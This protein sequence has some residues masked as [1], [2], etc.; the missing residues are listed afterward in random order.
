MVA[1]SADMIEAHPPSRYGVDLG[2]HHE[3]GAWMGARVSLG[4][5]AFSGATATV[6]R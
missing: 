3:P 6:A 2:P 4:L 1:T 5:Q